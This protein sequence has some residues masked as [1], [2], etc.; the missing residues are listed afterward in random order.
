M[1]TVLVTGASS[2]I[3]RELARCFAAAGA[4]L[5]L[6]ARNQAALQALAEELQQRHGSTSLILVQDLS[7][8]DAVDTLLAA[9]QAQAIAID[10]LVNNAGFGAYGR[11]AD[12]D[13]Q[14]QQQ[15][16][17]VNIH[18]LTELSYKLLPGMLARGKGGILN[19]ASTAAF[20]A[21]PMQSVY[22]ASKAYV[23]SFS[24]GL[25]EEYRGRG[26]HICCLCPGPTHTQF[27]NIAGMQNTWL[28]RLF[29]SA[30]RV[31]AIGY[32]GYHRGQVVIVAGGV[33]RIGT[34]LTRLLP[35]AWTRRLAQWLQSE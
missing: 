22:F 16:L 11:F 21:G 12:L 28:S 5:V 23:L 4:R 7:A 25:A 30:E 19:V 6:V 8:P 17:Q 26:L 2:G 35:R 20:Q 1:E 9:L 24:E 3:G 15:L 14:R 18:V 29:M 13:W 31:A 10:I 33:N 32:H 34:L 27:G